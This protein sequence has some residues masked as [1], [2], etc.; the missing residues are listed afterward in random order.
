MHHAPC[1]CTC[2]MHVHV[3]VHVHHAQCTVHS[4]P[5]ACACACARRARAR[6]PEHA[7]ERQRGA[8]FLIG[9]C[10]GV[11]SGRLAGRRGSFRP[12]E[13][14][15]SAS[16]C[17]PRTR[18]R[19]SRSAVLSTPAHQES[20]HDCADSQSICNVASGAPLVIVRHGMRRVGA[21]VDPLSVTVRVSERAPGSRH[22]VYC[23]S[24][25]ESEP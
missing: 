23:G 12:H 15:R 6:G 2:T 8:T 5:C 19:Q 21:T 20:V 14:L 22:P 10:R 11:S 3:H 16:F 17:A 25:S 1:T 18:P 4:A 7:R 13:L 24:L 9:Y